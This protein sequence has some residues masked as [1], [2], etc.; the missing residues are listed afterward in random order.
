MTSSYRA[1]LKTSSSKLCWWLERELLLPVLLFSSLK[2]L[3]SQSVVQVPIKCCCSCVYIIIFCK[4]FFVKI[5]LLYYFGGMS[6]KKM[7]SPTKIVATWFTAHWTGNW[8]FLKNTSR[9]YVIYKLTRATTSC[10]GPPWP[11]KQYE[12]IKLLLQLS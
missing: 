2:L 6:F 11:F 9:Y 4:T 12:L 8:I 3:P 7:L 1:T 5:V 10:G